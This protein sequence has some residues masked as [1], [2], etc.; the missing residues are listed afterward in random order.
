[1]ATQ[2]NPS[3]SSK[4]RIILRNLSKKQIE[5]LKLGGASA[6]GALGSN[7]LLAFVGRIN[8]AEEPELPANTPETQ[9]LAG[10]ENA[11]AV[12]C[13][14]PFAENISDDMS[15]GEAFKTAREEVGAG[16]F[17]E[18]HGHTYNTYTAEEWEAL[19]NDGQA[20][21]AASLH[22]SADFNNIQELEHE[23]LMADSSPEMEDPI[24]TAEAEEHMA[25][26]PRAD[27]PEIEADI[28]E[29]MPE[30]QIIE[31]PNLP[32]HQQVAP[33]AELNMDE[34]TIE[35]DVPDAPLA[36][37]HDIAMDEEDPL[38]PPQAQTVSEPVETEESA[39]EEV[40]E[41]VIVLDA[42]FNDIPEAVFID[43]DL[44]GMVDAI[45]L[46]QNA[47]GLPD[48]YLVDLD[49]DHVMESMIID[50][51][52]DD[53]QGDE[54]VIPLAEDEVISI[55]TDDVEDLFSDQHEDIILDGDYEIEEDLPDLDDDAD[56]SD[57]V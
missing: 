28:A 25:H 26:E 48:T 27:A 34:M 35:E 14:A 11:I 10:E 40:A 56:V 42:D 53:L 32:E 2:T 44:D 41:G 3:G 45:A 46:D 18:W 23:E 6:L 24:L 31:E 8:P 9:E 1:M 7:G 5:A 38:G 52:Q 29:D 16:G 54:E 39:I 17:F 12:Y 22:E 13:E 19:G 51:D 57:L 4:K 55:S 43:A 15:F 20:D 36:E 47:D 50:E 30:A 33:E 21:F 49:G 37:T